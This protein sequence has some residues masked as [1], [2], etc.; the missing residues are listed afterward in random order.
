MGALHGAFGALAAQLLFSQ[1]RDHDRQLVRRKRIAVMQHRSDREVL[2]AHWAIDDDLQALD[3]GEDIH[4]A[5]VATRAIM[6]EDEHQIISSA[7]RRLSSLM[8]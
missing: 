1:T 7:L 2:A 8:T 6:V 4:R 3:G 5:P